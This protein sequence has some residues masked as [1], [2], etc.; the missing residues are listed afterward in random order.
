MLAKITQHHEIRCAMQMM[1]EIRT[2]HTHLRHK[3]KKTALGGMILELGAAPGL[4][5][6]AAQLPREANWGL[7][8]TPQS[9]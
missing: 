9:P 4:R 5:R 7:L 2:T 1:H 6:W 8:G 3:K